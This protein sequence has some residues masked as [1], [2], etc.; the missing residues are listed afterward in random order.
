MR[1]LIVSCTLYD[2]GGLAMIRG[3][4]N[5]LGQ[6]DTQA[7]FR[8]LHALQHDRLGIMKTFREPEQNDE[9]FQ[10]ADVILDIGGLFACQKNK[11]NWLNLRNKHDKP[12]VYMAQSFK[13]IDPKLFHGTAIV[14]RGKRSAE[15]VRE[16]GFDVYIAPDLSFLV[17]PKEW[18][19]RHYERAFISHAGKRIDPMYDI[20]DLDTDIQII[21]KPPRGNEVYEPALPL[22]S[23]IGMPE[24]TFGLIASVGEVHT[25]RYQMACAAILAGKS[26]TIYDTG[27]I[28]YDKKYQDLLDCNGM[29]AEALRGAAMLSC[30]V[31]YECGR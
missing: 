16:H 25:A 6:L 21:T 12:Y 15:L 30:Q 7:E 9:A 23:F 27:N 17:E 20:C 31:A 14:S 4:M 3:A 2:G 26:V 10:W 11:Y 8:S 5:G 29:S 1:Y 19:G 18:T 24:E 28:E 13:N 22:N